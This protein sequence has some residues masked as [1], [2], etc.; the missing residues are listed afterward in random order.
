MTRTTAEIAIVGGGLV[1]GALAAALGSAGMEIVL[2]DREPPSQLL[3]ATFD[4]TATPAIARAGCASAWPAAAN[5]SGN[6]TATP[7][8]ISANPM[9]AT[10][11]L[12]A[13]TTS[14]P[15]QVPT[16]PQNRTT[17]VAP[18]FRTAK[19]PHSREITMVNAKAL[20]AVAAVPADVSSSFFK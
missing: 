9:M 17:R 11:G 10:T 3:D 2:I 19:S 4:D 20:Y 18:N 16:T 1:G 14:N 6:T 13:N 12:P 8:P 5:D 7:R 15:P